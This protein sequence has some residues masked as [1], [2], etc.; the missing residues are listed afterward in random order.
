MGNAVARHHLKHNQKMKMT[1]IHHGSS[2]VTLITSLAAALSLCATQSASAAFSATASNGGYIVNNGANLVVTIT[3]HGDMSSCKYK[4][5]EL[6]DQSSA[7]CLASG[8]GASSVSA[9]TSGNYIT[10]KCV[11]TAISPSALTHYYIFQNGSDDIYMADYITSEPTIGELRY[12]F[13]GQFSV[14]PNGPADSN[15]SGSTGPIESQDIMGHSNGQTTSKY[16]GNANEQSLSVVGA[17]GSGVGVFMAYGSRESSSGGPFYRD[18]ENQGSGTGGSSDQ[19]DQ[20]IYNYMN[21]GH[22]S[23]ESPRVNVLYGPYAYV[24]TTGSTPSVPDMSFVSNLGLT[25][26]VSAAGRG[27]VVL[28]GLSGTASA[29]A[30]T[31]VLTNAAAQYWCTAATSGTS[32]CDGMKP[33][34]YTLN[35]LK[36]Q[37]SVATVGGIVVKAGAA[38]TVHTI[39]ITGDPSTV[40][41]IWRI[42]DWDGTPLE[43][44]NA[45]LLW[46]MH[47]SDVRMSKWSAFTYTVGSTHS[48]S[49]PSCEFRGANSP[50]TINFT[51]TAAQAAAAHTLKIGITDAYNGG[52]P[53]VTINGHALS[54]PGSAPENTGRSLTVGSYRG[55]NFTF[56][57]SIPAG[58]FNAGANSMVIAPVSGGN[59]LSPWL[60]ASYSFDCLELDQ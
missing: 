28:N 47:P 57:W 10:I 21:S 53:G 17:T 1:R 4:G 24:F 46:Q 39:T 51:L 11:S 55:N 49:F 14:I 45:S 13:R 9:T 30:Y 35:V 22:N 2:F 15:N 54:I 56:G 37:I 3:S 12:I 31:Y 19:S 5:K 48:S 26:Y 40:A 50:I 60:S 29:Y 38:T 8:L 41:T 34:T 23:V 43:F 16:Y 27:R 20:Q 44:A 33:G 59:D 7:S 32:E 36:G 52:R 42:G 58:D 6:N 25:G 18:I